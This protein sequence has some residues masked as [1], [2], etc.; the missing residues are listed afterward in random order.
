[1]FFSKLPELHL[2]IDSVTNTRKQKSSNDAF[3]LKVILQLNWGVVL[4]LHFLITV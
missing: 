2:D 3:F 4:L 1:V